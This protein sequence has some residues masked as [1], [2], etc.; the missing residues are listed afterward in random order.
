MF[1]LFKRKPSQ[2][3]DFSSWVITLMDFVK[4]EFIKKN[5]KEEL[6]KAIFNNVQY[7]TEAFAKWE[8][9]V[10]NF[11]LADNIYG[12]AFVVSHLVNHD[13]SMLEIVMYSKMGYKASQGVLSFN[14]PNELFDWLDKK[15][16]PQKCNQI[17]MELLETLESQ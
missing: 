15:G 12:V 8:D 6:G 10:D 3:P 5:I 2:R 4:E 16:T 13:C 17:L 1:N 9:N 14:S 11:H 7:R